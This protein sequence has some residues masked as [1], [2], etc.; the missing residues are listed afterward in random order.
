MKAQHELVVTVKRCLD[1]FFACRQELSALRE[2]FVRRKAEEEAYHAREVSVSPFLS[3]RGKDVAGI[4]QQI[5]T[6]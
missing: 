1:L 5:Q 4:S 6:F 2:D 3:V